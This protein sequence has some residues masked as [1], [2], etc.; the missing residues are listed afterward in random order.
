MSKS[1]NVLAD[2]R[3]ALL[4]AEVAAWLHMFFGK[5]HEEFL[6]GN[7]ELDI[8]IPDDVRMD[9]PQLTDLLEDPWP[10]ET[11]EDLDLVVP[12]FQT[13]KLS[14]FSLIENHRTSLKELYEK[15]SSGF[16]RLM[17]DAHGRGSSAEKGVLA[18]FAQEQKTE[19]YPLTSLGFEINSFID[20]AKIQDKRQKLYDFLQ[21]RLQYLKDSKVRLSQDEWHQFRRG[22]VQKIEQYFRTT[23]AETRRPLSDVTL[24]DQTLA[25]VAFFKAI[26]AQNLL[27]GWKEPYTENLG[28][29]YRWR[30]L[31][32]GLDGLT[33]WGNSIRISDLLARQ[34]LVKKTLD[35]IRDLLEV[36]YPLGLEVY[37][38][39][40]GSVFVVPDVDELHV[41]TDIDGSQSLEEI[42]QGIADEAFSGETILSLDPTDKTRNMLSFGRLVIKPVPYPNPKI[43]W[44]RKEWHEEARRRDVCPVCGLRPQGPSRKAGDRKICDVCEKRRTNRSFQWLD[45][46]STTIWIDEIADFNGRLA[47]IV[48]Q[49][50][51][52][53]WLSS[54]SFNTVLALDPKSGS[55]KNPQGETKL[56][57][58]AELVANI[59]EGLRRD[60]NTFRRGSLLRWLVPSVIRDLTTTVRAFYNIRILDTDLEQIIMVPRFRT[61]A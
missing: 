27:M 49:F 22:F 47:L 42:L 52:A 45:H 50:D 10:S 30:L 31:K 48:G 33:F 25:S 28:E 12:D 36:T 19:V 39:E 3:D 8:S 59:Q 34:E 4:L 54:S 43:E 26:L 56:F 24:F 58:L 32:V 14:I 46:L 51:V 15:G 41:K 35:R 53:K 17:V 5:Y 29:Q 57:D 21:I 61:V 6:R 11:W 60:T 1:L 44:L 18:R 20:L 55:I 16:L 2:N 13:Q 40:N 9:F 7:H 37:R 38:D 23:V